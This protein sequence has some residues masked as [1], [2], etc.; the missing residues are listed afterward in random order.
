MEERPLH[1]FRAGLVNRVQRFVLRGDVLN[2]KITSILF[3]PYW[4]SV[5]QHE[6]LQPDLKLEDEDEICVFSNTVL[7]TQ[8]P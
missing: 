5:Q 6:E 3:P 8:T 4:H 1:I 7:Q 2:L